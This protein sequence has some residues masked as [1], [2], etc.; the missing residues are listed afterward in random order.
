METRGEM[1][2]ILFFILNCILTI[3]NLL[4]LYVI[5]YG[6]PISNIF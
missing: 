4:T 6:N 1:I 3:I 5:L 2:N